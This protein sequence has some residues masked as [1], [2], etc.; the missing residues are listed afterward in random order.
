MS[1]SR[2]QARVAP[3]TL[4]QST[5]T[6]YSKEKESVISAP[7]KQNQ[8]SCLPE[9]RNPSNRPKNIPD[10]ISRLDP[11]CKRPLPLPHDPANDLP[12]G[13]IQ[14]PHGGVE[15]VRFLEEEVVIGRYL[16]WRAIEIR[17]G[18]HDDDA[19]EVDQLGFGGS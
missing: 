14:I 3:S 7:T 19:G 1:Q 6:D 10:I 2:V 12:P 4:H 16:R 11:L 18:P 5:D 13:K 9:I 17:G 8:V 15:R